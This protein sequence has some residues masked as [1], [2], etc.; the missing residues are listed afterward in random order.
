MIGF[1][2]INKLSQFVKINKDQNHTL[3]KNNLVYKISCNDC[4]VSYVGQTKR[5]LKTRLNEHNNNLKQDKSKHSII[6]EHITKYDHSFDW[7]NMRIMDRESNYFKR[8][9]SEMIHIKE[10]K[11]GLNLNSD[12]ELLDESSFDILKELTY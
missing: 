5:Q 9:V 7:D 2:C 3:S 4:D 10:Q 1:R 8:I 6:S 11:S 12:T